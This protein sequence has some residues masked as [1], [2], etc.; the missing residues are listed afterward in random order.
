MLTVG[1]ESAEWLLQ[2][3]AGFHGCRER[4]PPSCNGRGGA[5]TVDRLIIEEIGGWALFQSLLETLAAIGARHG[6]GIAAVASRWVLEQPRVAGVII[7]ARDTKHL[8]RY[9]EWFRFRLT[10]QDRRA[11]DAVRAAM[12][13]P[14]GDVFDLE[15]DRSGPHGRIMKYDLNAR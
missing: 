4:H 10:A 3:L 15:R 5:L 12:T 14:P 9:A 11:I 13:V 1:S 2:A 7:G 8:D 6:V